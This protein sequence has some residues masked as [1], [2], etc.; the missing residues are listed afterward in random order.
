MYK[1]QKV[2]A[3]NAQG[4]GIKK[5]SKDTKNIQK[6]SE[7]VSEEQPPTRVPSQGLHKDH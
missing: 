7:E 4:I 2:K 6:H 1:W 3:M 5:D